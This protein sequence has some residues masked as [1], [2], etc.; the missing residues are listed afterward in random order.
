MATVREIRRSVFLA[1]CFVFSLA[2]ALPSRLAVPQ[3]VGASRVHAA[4][5][6]N[7]PSPGLWAKYGLQLG[8][9]PLRVRLIRTALAAAGP[10]LNPGAFMSGMG[11][12]GRNR[13]CTVT[14][15]ISGARRN[16]ICSTTTTCGSSTPPPLPPPSTVLPTSHPPLATCTVLTQNTV[17]HKLSFNTYSSCAVRDCCW[18]GSHNGACA[19]VS[20]YKNYGDGGGSGGGGG[21]G[22][23]NC[24]CT[25]YYAEC[26]YAC[27]EYCT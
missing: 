6:L 25:W 17:C 14:Y 19:T 5:M 21:G 23:G 16:T 8:I 4:L 22:G 1:I 13:H 26:A 20:T 18:T 15:T 7:L 12:G 24:Y 9:R 3:L 2:R 27:D 10:R 11:S